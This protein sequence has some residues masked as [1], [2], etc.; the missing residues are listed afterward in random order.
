MTVPTWYG[1]YVGLGTSDDLVQINPQPHSAVGPIHQEVVTAVSS[2]TFYQGRSTHEW[3]WIA[4]KLSVWYA[5]I[6]AYFPNDEASID[7][8]FSTRNEKTGLWET[9]YGALR[10]PEFN[11]DVNRKLGR[12][13]SVKWVFTEK[14]IIEV[15]SV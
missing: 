10:Q 14:Q 11:Q 7:V 9:V 1:L 3:F 12:V 8:T 6:N 5:D 15:Q 4:K 2:K 13:E